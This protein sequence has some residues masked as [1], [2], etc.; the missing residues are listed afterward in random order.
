MF[1][2]Q[3]CCGEQKRKKQRIAVV[4]HRKSIYTG[5]LEKFLKKSGFILDIYRPI[6]GQKLPDTLQ[7]Y[8]GVVI[9]GGKMSVNDRD[10]YIGKEID[11]ISLLLKE[12]KPF[13]G[14][15]LGAQ[16]LARNLGGRVGTRSDG[17]VE[18]GWYPLEATP[19]GKELMQWPEM[20]Y[21]FHNEG[22]YDL[23]K[24]AVLLATGQTYPVQAF[25][26]GKNAWGFQFHAEFT[27]AMMRRLIVHSAQELTEKGA[28]P[29]SAH[30][31]GRL[32]YD[33]ALSQWFENTLQYIFGASSALV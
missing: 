21:H 4:I 20:V 12:N 25:R 22:I 23:P 9:L 17:T 5:R 18:I 11:W 30:F 27:L 33:K 2:V 6:L 1:L 29:A 14:I 32:I 3:S 10:A 28:Q 13:L 19:Q 15:C 31:K 7:N 8:A 26:Y 24:E 16:M